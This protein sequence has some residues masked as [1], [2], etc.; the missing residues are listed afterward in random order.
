M[1]TLAIGVHHFKHCKCVH[2]CPRLTSCVHGGRQTT[3]LS[4]ADSFFNLHKGPGVEAIPDYNAG[5]VR[6]LKL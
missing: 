6:G 2:Y 4:L 3:C 1:N 5:E